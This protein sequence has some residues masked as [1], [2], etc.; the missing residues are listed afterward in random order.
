MAGAKRRTVNVTVGGQTFAPDDKIPADLEK[1]I[2]N[3]K[4]YAEPESAPADPPA[5]DSGDDP[6]DKA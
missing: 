2:D 3:P 1:L 5:E 6:A 4:V